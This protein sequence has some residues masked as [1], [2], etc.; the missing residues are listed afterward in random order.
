MSKIVS[1]FGALFLIAVF[2]P[3]TRADPLVVTSGTLSVT[4][5]AGGPN[6]GP[7]FTFSG[8]NFSVSGGGVETGSVGSQ[9]ACSPCKAGET[10]GVNAFLAGSTLGS[11]TVTVDGVSHSGGF[12]GVFQFSGPPVVVPTAFSDVTITSPFMFTGNLS[13]CS[14]NCGFTP[15]VFSV[16]GLTGAGTATINLTFLTTIQGVPIYNFRSITYNFEEVPEPA[17]VLLLGGGL[18]GLATKL[19]HHVRVKRRQESDA[20]KAS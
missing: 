16:T 18:I 5:L 19:G 2:S 3:A 15:V 17:S 9:I 6:S 12:A 1:T 8:T 7:H 13:V 11:G 14:G 20:D 10:I 4:G